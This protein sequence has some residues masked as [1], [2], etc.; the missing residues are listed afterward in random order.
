M[1]GTIGM[2]LAARHPDAISKLMVV[3]IPPYV[4]ALMVPPGTPSETIKQA[5]DGMAAQMMVTDS[6]VRRQQVEAMV[7]SMIN[8]AAMRPIAVDEL[9]KS[10]PEVSARAFRDVILT[11]LGPELP[12]IVVPTTVLYVTPKGAQ[13]TD[14]QIDAFY[15]TAY[16]PLKGAV[17]KRVPDSA[18]VIM[19]DAPERFQSEVVA[20]LR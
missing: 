8:N 4:G 2:M 15:K 19:W 20:F 6:A 16:A 14:A 3:D 17:V 10:D 9:L 11:D 13:V 12:K 5:A 18:H 1:G 7:A